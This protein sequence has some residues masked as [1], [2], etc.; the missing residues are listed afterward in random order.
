VTAVLIQRLEE[1]VPH[2]MAKVDMIAGTSGGGI[3]ALLLAAGYDSKQCQR[4]AEDAIEQIFTNSAW[5]MMNPFV[6]RYSGREKE[7]LLKQY[8]GERSMGGLNKLAMVTAVNLKEAARLGIGRNRSASD[9]TARLVGVGHL[10][11]NAWV[12]QVGARRSSRTCP[13]Q[14]GAL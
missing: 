6:A 14:K 7:R 3:L 4:I 8:L 1:K 10:T 9:D 11:D 12:S 5:R 2:L 13:T